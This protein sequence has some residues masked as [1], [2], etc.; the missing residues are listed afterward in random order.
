MGYWLV[1][2]YIHVLEKGVLKMQYAVFSTYTDSI[3][4]AGKTGIFNAYRL[5]NLNHSGYNYDFSDSKYYF[6]PA[7]NTLVTQNTGL[8]AKIV[9]R[10]KSTPA[11]N[12][13]VRSKLDERTYV[14]KV[15]AR[16][17]ELLECARKQILG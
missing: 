17:G 2:Y 7:L 13:N 4:I 11:F 12:L 10:Q 16:C 8:H 1:V 3:T 14:K 6:V 15:N 9:S 5:K